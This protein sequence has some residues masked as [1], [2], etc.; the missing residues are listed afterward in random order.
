M[1]HVWLL[2]P[3]P[4]SPRLMKTPVAS[5]PLPQGGEGCKVRIGA[6]RNVETPGKGAAFP[7]SKRR[8][9]KSSANAQTVFWTQVTS[10]RPRGVPL[11]CGAGV[12]PVTGTARMAVPRFGCGSAALRLLSGTN[13]L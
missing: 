12:P 13:I 1:K 3:S 5:H 10:G 11:H 4:V 9:R 6:F 2:T 7:Q 8:S